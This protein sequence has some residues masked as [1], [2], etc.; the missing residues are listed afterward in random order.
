MPLI[1]NLSLTAT[2]S[3]E[4]MHSIKRIA[5]I[6]SRSFENSV[7]EKLALKRGVS[8]FLS[9]GTFGNGRQASPELLEFAASGHAL[10]S[11]LTFRSLKKP[12]V[13]PKTHFMDTMLAY[14]GSYEPAEAGALAHTWTLAELKGL[15]LWALDK[16][17]G[18][19]VRSNGYLVNGLSYCD[20]LNGKFS[21]LRVGDDVCILWPFEIG[22]PQPEYARVDKIAV[23]LAERELD[24][25]ACVLVFP[26]WWK[27]MG[28]EDDRC[29]HPLR[30]TAIVSL[31]PKN[32]G[33]RKW[34][35]AEDIQDTVMVVHSCG[36]KCLP[37][38]ETGVQLHTGAKWEVW[39]RDNGLRLPTSDAE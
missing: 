20:P 27:Q 21:H 22:N 8:H 39:D 26:I 33:S 31:D 4:R 38:D 1:R 10:L 28:K 16:A 7:M 12:V 9:G 29:E 19:T 13:N 25:I 30:K 24:V 34:A 18:L 2:G 15:Q 14:G 36:A 17:E 23:V 32:S 11:S 37:D 3:L 5:N 35:S 6:G